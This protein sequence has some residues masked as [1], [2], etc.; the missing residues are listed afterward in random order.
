VHGL[1]QTMCYVIFVIQKLKVRHVL[2]VMLCEKN[3]YENILRY[4]IGKKDKPQ[5]RNDMEAIRSHLHLRPLGNT[6]KPF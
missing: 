6:G 1:M 5:V 4:L 2:Y 3:L